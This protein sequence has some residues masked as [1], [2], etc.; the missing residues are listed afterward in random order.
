LTLGLVAA[1]GNAEAETGA[2]LA[3]LGVVYELQK[4]AEPRPNRVHVLRV[5]LA[6]ERVQPVVVV[7]PDPDGEGPAE[8]ALTDPRKLADH[9]AVLAF[10]NTNPWDSLP[11]ASGAKNRSWFE[12][13]PV[14]ILGLAASGGEVR[15]PAGP[16]EA[17]AWLE[18]SG[19]FRL[20]E[21][22]AGSQV[23]EG[24]AGF[25]PV[26]RAGVV[27]SAPGGPMHP[28]TAIGSDAAGRK[29]WLVV[30]DGRQ[31]KFSEGMTLHELGKVML[32]LGCWSAT[33]LDGGG[34]S[35]MGLAGVD[36][37][38]KLVNSPSDRLLGGS[39]K[40]RPVPV[41]L[42]LQRHPREASPGE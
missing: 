13:Q 41:I 36:G 6:A 7:A 20:G 33:N 29:L 3:T 40:V 39:S 24:I 14:D 32:E 28:R 31:A 23:V 11:D 9:P 21:V 15:S 42:T 17:S 12:G 8:A 38:L 18:R 27:V 25:Q 35:V 26:V 22:A 5:D 10:V 16:G 30:V 1:A 19:R 37:R 34:S 4:L 2:E